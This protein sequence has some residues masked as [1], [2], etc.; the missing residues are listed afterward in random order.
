MAE[1]DREIAEFDL[2]ES[3]EVDDEEEEEEE[4]MEP[5]VGRMAPT[6]WDLDGV[7]VYL[8]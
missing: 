5:L 7:S 3:D 1:M 6:V 4:E 2:F 8:K